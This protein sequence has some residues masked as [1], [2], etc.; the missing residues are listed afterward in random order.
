MPC[1]KTLAIILAAT[2]LLRGQQY[3][4]VL[5]GGHVIDPG[6]QIDAVLDVA[7]S[8][9][10]IAAVQAGIP[11][12]QAARTIDVTGLYIVPG[13]VDLHAHV[14]GYADSL[15]PD[16]SALPAGTTTIVDAGGSGWRTFDDF[17][18]TVITP[19]KTRVFASINIVGAGM[20]GEKAESNTADVDSAKT[21]EAIER[22]RDVIVG[23]KTAHF[24]L[25][26]W[27]AI[28]RAVA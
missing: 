10:K 27:T 3:D 21:A 20:V 4:I 8:A 18:R 11:A 24:G 1:F 28:D 13:L 25:P 14:Y 12:A 22:N 26:G 17:R 16:D 23:I 6:N 9:G 2:A 5:K 15:V 19:S 7:I